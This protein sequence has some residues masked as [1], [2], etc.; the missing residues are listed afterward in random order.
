MIALIGTC[1]DTADRGCV[2]VG[3]GS[4]FHVSVICR[5]IPSLSPSTICHWKISGNWPQT[6]W[7]HWHS[8]ASLGLLTTEMVSDV[9][10]KAS[11]QWDAAHS[12]QGMLRGLQNKFILFFNYWK[13]LKCRPIEIPGG[14]GDCYI[15]GLLAQYQ[16]EAQISVQC[17]KCDAATVLTPLIWEWYIAGATTIVQKVCGSTSFTDSV[18]VISDCITG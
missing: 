17:C 11:L 14:F 12:L 10:F 2:D 16:G 13:L 4:W 3:E 15:C 9:T 18:C 7:K 6:G 1:A 8:N 5:R